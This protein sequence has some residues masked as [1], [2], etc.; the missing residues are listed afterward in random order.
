MPAGSGCGAAR[1]D[2]A[3]AEAGLRA[4]LA[5]GADDPGLIGHE[6]LPA[7]AR[8]LVRRGDPAERRRRWP[9]RP[10]TPPAPTCCCGWCRPAS[11]TSST[12]G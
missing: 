8:L 4:L 11:P 2:W 3:E 10:S 5:D 7:L 12:P 6:T 9:P 1:G